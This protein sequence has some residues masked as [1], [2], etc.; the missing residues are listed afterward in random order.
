MLGAARYV[1]Y[2]ESTATRLS[3]LARKLIQEY[4][5]SVVGIRRRSDSRASFEKRL[6]EFDGVGPKT[7]E[8]FMAQAGQ[9][10]Y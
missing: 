8:I 4:D 3:S 7:V 1:R 6:L 9:V 2:D 10:L 5:A